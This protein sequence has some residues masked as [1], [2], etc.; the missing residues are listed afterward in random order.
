[1]ERASS[2]LHNRYEITKVRESFLATSSWSVLDDSSNRALPA[3][4][5]R[6]V[7]EKARHC[8]GLKLGRKAVVQSDGN[9]SV[10]RFV[11]CAAC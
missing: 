6:P 11:A 8:D 1:L 4:C 7:P 5:E 2:I 10:G 3:P 9:R